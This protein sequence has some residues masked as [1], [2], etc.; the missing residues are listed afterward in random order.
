M[1]NK[2][3]FCSRCVMD[4]SAKE[5]V[6]DEKGVCNFCYQA[7]KALLNMELEKK[8]LDKLIKRIKKD[9]EGKLY[10]CLVGLSGGLDSS[11]AL[12]YAVK[13]GLRPLCF[14]IDNGWN[15][16]LADENIMRLVE[17]LRVPFFRYTIDILKFRELQG[18]FIKAGQ[19]NIEVPT[20]HILMASTYEMARKHKIKWIISGW[21]TV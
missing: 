13:N 14:S 18:A 12:H 6:L 9:G 5:L 1:G 16:P 11:T 7:Q 8:N 10:D 17:T 2:L 20:D 19:V 21:N 4:G 3:T 15:N